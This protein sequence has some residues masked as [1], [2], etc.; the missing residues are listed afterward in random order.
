MYNIQYSIVNLYPHLSKLRFR[1]KTSV[2]LVCAYRNSKLLIKKLLT[3]LIKLNY[4]RNYRVR[5]VIKPVCQIWY[6]CSTFPQYSTLHVLKVIKRVY[7]NH[8]TLNYEKTTTTSNCNLE[9]VISSTAQVWKSTLLTGL[10][11]N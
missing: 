1:N 10:H 6:I 9:E 11:E 3:F 5:K 7:I 4:D 8:P 2:I